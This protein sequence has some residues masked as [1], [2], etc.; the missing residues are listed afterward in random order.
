LLVTTVAPI[1]RAERAIRTSFTREG[2]PLT[3]YP[4]D[5]RPPDLGVATP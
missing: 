2:G 4:R 1:E 5:S 3:R